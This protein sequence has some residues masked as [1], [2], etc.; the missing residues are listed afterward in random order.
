MWQTVVMVVFAGVAGTDA[1]HVEQQLG[2]LLRH[3]AHVE[4]V[5]VS[6]SDREQLGGHGDRAPRVIE[7]LGENGVVAGQVVEGKHGKQR[8]RV[9][10]YDAEGN[11]V[12]QVEVPL[13][14]GAL[15]KSGVSML[16][17]AI[18]ADAMSLADE[19]R[20]AK[21][22]RSASTKKDKKAARDR[23]ERAERSE[24]KSHAERDDA[25]PA[26]DGAASGD[27][28]ASSGDSG[29]PAGEETARADT[30]DEEDPLHEGGAGTS[31]TESASVEAAGDESPPLRIGLSA[32]AGVLSRNFH[33]TIKAIT[34]YSA[35]AVGGVRLAGEIALRHLRLDFQGERSLSM[36]T[37]MDSDTNAATEVGMWQIGLAWAA[38]AGGFTLVPGV[39]VGRRWF[40]IDTES[41]DRSPD[42][43]Y[44]YLVAGL[45]V[46]HPVGRS[47]VLLARVDFE[48]VVGGTA[49]TEAAYGKASRWGYDLGFGADVQLSRYWL[50]RAEAGWQSFVSAFAEGGGAEDRYLEGT[51]SLGARY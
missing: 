14:D 10:V 49:D 5:K 47:V 28:G 27:D 2:A 38:R 40:S 34:P 29:D 21:K 45:H 48:P 30:G 1:E 9:F 41:A 13:E 50:V 39:G 43:E 12:S 36:V 35:P 15:T 7:K 11:V 19:A 42:N 8:L 3:D 26:E 37:A 51:L 32:G 6:A 44:L 46:S 25:E 31:V 20:K 4:R 23:D 24:R 17:E 33:P 18:V 16:R 22:S